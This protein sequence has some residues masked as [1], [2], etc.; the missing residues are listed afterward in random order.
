MAAAG[1]TRDALYHQFR[2]KTELFEAVLEGVE[3]EIA[4]ELAR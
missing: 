1:V 4:A 2:D 3:A